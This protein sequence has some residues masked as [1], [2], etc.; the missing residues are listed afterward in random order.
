MKDFERIKKLKENADIA[1]DRLI[2]IESDL[3][4]IGAI[5]EAKSLSTIIGRLEY[6]QNK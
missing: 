4:E 3:K 2:Q 6:W 1:K 5:R